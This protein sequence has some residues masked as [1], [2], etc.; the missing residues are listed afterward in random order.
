MI[1]EHFFITHTHMNIKPLKFERF[2][3]TVQ[4]TKIEDTYR[5]TRWVKQPI[6]TLTF[7]TL[8]VSTV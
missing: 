2:E 5:N 8:V 4:G 3:H 1:D 6:E 7:V